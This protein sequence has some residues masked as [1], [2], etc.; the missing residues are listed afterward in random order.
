[1]TDTSHR[2]DVV[3][4]VVG[5]ENVMN[6]T[7]AEAKVPELLLERPDSYSYV[8][9]QSLLFSVEVVAIT[10]ATTAKGYK[11]QHFSGYFLQKYKIIHNSFYLFIFISYLCTLLRFSL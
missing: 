4:V 3:G 2:L 1:M 11:F 9:Y 5:Y 8:Y 7:K 6:G 10:A